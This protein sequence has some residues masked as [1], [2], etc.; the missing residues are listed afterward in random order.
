MIDS[1]NKVAHQ[2][3]ETD[4]ILVAS[5]ENCQLQL[6]EFNHETHLKL[7]YFY[8]VQQN[9]NQAIYSMSK[10]LKS[11]LKAN[12]VDSQKFHA[13]LTHAWLLA[14]KNFMQHSPPMRSSEEFIKHNPALLNKDLLAYHYSQDLLFSS[15]A[16]KRYVHPDINPFPE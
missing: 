10:T 7:A 2:I 15:K 6:A 9:M 8:L 1:C 4:R 16:R 14:V 11:F 12:G 3:C 5:I 13:T